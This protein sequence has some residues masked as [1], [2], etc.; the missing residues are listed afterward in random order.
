MALCT[1]GEISLAGSTVGRSVACELG[2]SGTSSINMNESAVRGLADRSTAG[3]S[4]S[5]SNFYGKSDFPAPASGTLGSYDAAWGGYYIGTL[6]GN[7]LFT[8]P[9]ATGCASCPWRTTRSTTANA[10]NL[11]DGY[12]N[13]YTGHQPKSEHL[14]AN[15]TATRTIGGF[16]DWYLPAINELSQ[17]Y[18]NRY[19]TPSGQGWPATFIWS[20]T[21]GSNLSGCFRSFSNGYIGINSKRNYRPTRAMRRHPI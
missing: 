17:T 7:Y 19:T 12:A 16:T 4:I 9:N 13:T 2:R 20:S 6:S 15:F 3:S 11:N 18:N 8:A 1:S 10:S 14:A 21:Q 5:L